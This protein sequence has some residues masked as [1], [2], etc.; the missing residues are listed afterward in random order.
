MVFWIAAFVSLAIFYY[1]NN[2]AKQNREQKKDRRLERHLHFME[3]LRK[4]SNKDTIEDTPT[5]AT[6][7]N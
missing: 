2:M 3:Q 1:A 4:D 5:S 7:D 6:N